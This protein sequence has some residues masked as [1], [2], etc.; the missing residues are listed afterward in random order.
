MASVLQVATI[1]DQGGNANAIEIANS[2]ANVTINNLAGGAIGSNVTFP[3]GHI[4][5]VQGAIATDSSST[6]YDF[7]V[8]SNDTD[9]GTVVLGTDYSTSVLSSASNKLVISVC[10]DA[11]M[12]STTNTD[13]WRI[14]LKGTGILNTSGF[15]R[16]HS[17]NPNFHYGIPHYHEASLSAQILATPG[18]TNPSYSIN[19]LLAQGSSS[20]YIKNIQWTFMEVQA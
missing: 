11:W 19:C 10:F 4:V 6:D 2:S 18:Q 15:N 9:V 5:G 7:A 13:H 3:A 12:T 16:G 1:K 8:S 20:L 17:I 14:H